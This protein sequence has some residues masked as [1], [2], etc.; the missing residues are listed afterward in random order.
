MRRRRWGRDG[1][2]RGRNANFFLSFSLETRSSWQRARALIIQSVYVYIYMYGE[3]TKRMRK[4]K[5]TVLR[6]CVYTER[7]FRDTDWNRKNGSFRPL[8]GPH[9]ALFRRPLRA[10]INGRMPG[11]PL[12]PFD[13]CPR[14]VS[15]TPKRQRALFFS[16]RT[17]TRNHIICSLTAE[18]LSKTEKKRKSSP[19]P[20]CSLRTLPSAPS[21]KPRVDGGHTST[22]SVH[23]KMSALHDILF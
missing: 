10:V 6:V 9:T 21:L 8:T 22:V 7:P 1:G 23:R 12:P 13:A 2:E 14:T 20:P 11:R 16:F 15:T 4:K 3:K 5:P 17:C 18:N 19:A